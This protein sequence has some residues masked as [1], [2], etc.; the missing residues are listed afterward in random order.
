L[1]FL[2]SLSYKVA[3]YFCY[4]MEDGSFS[5]SSAAMSSPQGPVQRLASPQGHRMPSPQG[6]TMGRP[7]PGQQP[8]Q[9]SEQMR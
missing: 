4:Q 2:I 9:F 5:P 1:L 8:Q 7:Q 6:M 3:L